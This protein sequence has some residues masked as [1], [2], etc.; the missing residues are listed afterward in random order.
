MALQRLSRAQRF[1][2]MSA[3]GFALYLFGAWVT[4]LGEHLPYGSVTFTNVSS[5]I[6]VGGLHLWVRFVIWLALI[7]TWLGVSIPLFRGSSKSIRRVPS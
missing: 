7:S 3:L 2:I 4:A 6:V 5:S 1:V